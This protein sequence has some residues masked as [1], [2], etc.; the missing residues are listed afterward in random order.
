[1]R[2]FLENMF[3]SEKNYTNPAI[4]QMVKMGAHHDDFQHYFEI[5]YSVCSANGEAILCPD[6]QQLKASN[7][8]Y[9]LVDMIQLL[10]DEGADI[11]AKEK[12]SEQTALHTFIA[13]YNL[14]HRSNYDRNKTSAVV[15]KLIENGADVNATDHLQRTPLNIECDGGGSSE[16]VEILLQS[17]SDIN[18]KDVFGRTPLMTAAYRCDNSASTEIVKL[19]LEYNADVNVRNKDGTSAVIHALSGGCT[20]HVKLILEKNV[21]IYAI[22]VKGNTVCDIAESY[23]QWSLFGCSW[24][25]NWYKKW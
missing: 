19:L 21:D 15:R 12:F 18:A 22:D 7:P 9:A 5:F 6:V 17:N 1:M 3:S 13:S 2:A 14:M 4:H 23:Q 11:N 25:K 16:I 24:F 10:V 20:E 8:N